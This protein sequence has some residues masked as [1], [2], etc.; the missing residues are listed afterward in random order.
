MHTPDATPLPFEPLRTQGAD[1]A[2]PARL[3]L[4][5]RIIAEGL[6]NAGLR[7][8]LLSEHTPP[9]SEHVLGDETGGV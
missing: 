3:P 9:V 5:E 7:E 4:R 6:T 2:A 1:V 8:Q